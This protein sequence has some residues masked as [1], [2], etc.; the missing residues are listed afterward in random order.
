[1]HDSRHNL[2]FCSNPFSCVSIL[3]QW[4]VSQKVLASKQM[5]RSLSSMATAVIATPHH[6]ATVR[7]LQTQVSSAINRCHGCHGCWG[8]RVCG[9]SLCCMRRWMS[10]HCDSPLLVEPMLALQIH[11][12]RCSRT[13]CT[14]M[15]VVAHSTCSSHSTL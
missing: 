14:R 3:L 9:A 4:D 15:P 8:R 2:C 11:T 6:Q 5:M 7:C 1:M 13:P 10:C 12:P